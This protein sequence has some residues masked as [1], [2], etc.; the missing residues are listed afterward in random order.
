MESQVQTG[1]AIDLGT[2]YVT[3]FN[4]LNNRCKYFKFRFKDADGW[5][6]YLLNY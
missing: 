5:K 1:F 3:P 6:R 2:Y 4:G